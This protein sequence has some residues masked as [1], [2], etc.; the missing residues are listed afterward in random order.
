M[1]EQNLEKSNFHCQIFFN[2][3]PEKPSLW[4]PTNCETETIYYYYART[5][6][7]DNDRIC[8][9]FDFGDGCGHTVGCYFESG[10]VCK[11]FHC[12]E[13]VGIY[14]ITVIAKDEHNACSEPSD[15]LAVSVPKIYKILLQDCLSTI[16][17]MNFYI[18]LSC[19]YQPEFCR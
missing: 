3:P 10:E 16:S 12:W 13:K 18:D 1:Q 17:C 14:K 4:G 15:P 9:C 6:D 8:Y 11:T 2:S 7:P 19:A 5:T